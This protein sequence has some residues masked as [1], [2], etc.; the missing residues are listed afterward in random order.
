MNY[1]EIYNILKSSSWH[2]D[3]EMEQYINHIKDNLSK[4]IVN[5]CIDSNKEMIMDE[6]RNQKSISD[7]NHFAAMV[8]CNSV[9][10]VSMHTIF[11]N[12]QC[13]TVSLSS[14]AIAWQIPIFAD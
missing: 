1:K 10:Q 13:P 9:V 7:I 5:I 12:I 11:K 4:N 2:F 8:I 14:P 6:F 3:N